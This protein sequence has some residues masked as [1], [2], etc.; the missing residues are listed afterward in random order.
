MSNES[1]DIFPFAPDGPTEQERAEERA[2]WE[3]MRAIDRAA[4]ALVA[5][6]EAEALLGQYDDDPSPYA[7]NW[8]EE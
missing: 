6:L 7:G 8:S 1:D 2:Y 3:R 5:E 4:D